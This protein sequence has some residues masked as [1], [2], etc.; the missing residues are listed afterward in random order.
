MRPSG[1]SGCCPTLLWRY[2]WC[3]VAGAGTPLIAAF[4]RL[5]SVGPPRRRGSNRPSRGGV[6]G[7]AD[8]FLTAAGRTL[9]TKRR[10]TRRRFSRRL[11][12]GPALPLVRSLA[13]VPRCTCRSR[14]VMR[15]VRRSLSPRWC[16]LGRML[17]GSQ[18]LKGHQEGQDG[19]TLGGRPAAAQV[20]RRAE[21]ARAGAGRVGAGRRDH[22]R[23]PR[24]RRRRWP[25]T[26]YSQVPAPPSTPVQLPLLHWSGAVHGSPNCSPGTQWRD[27]L[28]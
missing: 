5:D 21:A 27:A 4:C 8:A 12:R 18:C 7:L 24:G 6:R 13:R 23:S 17:S 26:R 19:R 20:R 22:L 11:P 9:W 1:S 28:Q 3:V 10:G 16:Q 2:G 15:S 14:M 25:R